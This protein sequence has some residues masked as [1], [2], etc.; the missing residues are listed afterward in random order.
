MSQQSDQDSIAFVVD[1]DLAE[2]QDTQQQTTADTTEVKSDKQTAMPDDAE[3]NSSFVSSNSDSQQTSVHAD[4]DAELAMQ[5]AVQ[6]LGTDTPDYSK[7]LDQCQRWC[8]ADKHQL[9][10]DTL[11]AIPENLRTPEIYSE[12]GRAYNNVAKPDEE[13]CFKKALK[14]LLPYEEYFKQDHRW[15]FRVAY[16][17]YYLDQEW[18]A[19]YY[20]AQALEARPGDQDSQNFIEDCR[21]GLARPTFRHNF[22]DRVRTMWQKFNEHEQEWLEKINNAGLDTPVFN[23]IG[24]VLQTA[25]NPLS[26]SI[27][28]NMLKGQNKVDPDDPKPYLI[29]DLKQNSA[30]TMILALNYLVRQAPDNIKQNWN[31]RVGQGA[32]EVESYISKHFTLEQKDL[33]FKLF[34]VEETAKLD[35]ESAENINSLQPSELDVYD[36][37]V[38]TGELDEF[39][40]DET[41]HDAKSNDAVPNHPMQ[42]DE[43]A[44]TTAL[45]DET[46][47]TSEVNDESVLTSE[48]NDET[49]I[50]AEQNTKIACSQETQA[51]SKSST[52]KSRPVAA[53][54]STDDSGIISDPSVKYTLFIYNDTIAKQ[55]EQYY[56]QKTD[57]N[58]L[59]LQEL[60]E[61]VIAMTNQIAGE[62]T[63]LAA[64]NSFRITG[65]KQFFDRL[66]GQAQPLEKLP[67]ALLKRGYPTILTG[68]EFERDF[69]LTK[70]TLTPELDYDAF[71]RFDIFKGES[72]V[73]RICNAFYHQDDDI[74]NL[75][76]SNGI[77]VG[78]IHY[79]IASAEHPQTT[80]TSERKELQDK[81]I[82]AINR[83]PDFKVF[84]KAF[85]AYNDYIDVLCFGDIF[86]LFKLVFDCCDEMTLK[87]NVNFGPF[88][89]LPSSNIYN[90]EVAHQQAEKLASLL[91]R[92]HDNAACT[93][94][95]QNDKA[96]AEQVDTN[97]HDEHSL[98]EKV[99][100]SEEEKAH[101]RANVMAALSTSQIAAEDL[102]DGDLTDD[103]LA[104]VEGVTDDVLAVED[105]SA[106]VA[107]AEKDE[108]T[109]KSQQN[110][111]PNAQQKKAQP[112]RRTAKSKKASSK[113]K[114]DAV[115]AGDVT[116]DNVTTADAT[117][118]ERALAEDSVSIVIEDA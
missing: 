43:L 83:H 32:D 44:L 97:A 79:E 40:L 8:E 93:N 19:I 11:E 100:L 117:T 99:Q 61:S 31:L 28:Q 66:Q 106:K 102:A 18:L 74:I 108:K 56:N 73:P 23:E 55:F 38:A 15:N 82:A 72:R 62:C 88:R 104:V 17:Y 6:T 27:K 20:F 68:E 105:E 77:A 34:T 24:D 60:S 103:A 95:N 81:L 36:D 71:W 63:V 47:L 16:S 118:N 84:G 75:M 90:Q 9:I 80:E 101:L 110:V 30:F 107:L 92:N 70:Y 98:A 112:K 3:Q 50:A 86:M 42:S 91:N 64:I 1:D 48:V 5:V 111:A 113:Q 89:N 37:R 54:I 76:H 14:C 33:F 4:N 29:F 21:M 114:S 109:A 78:F 41:T 35:Q 12:L 96:D 51:Q 57:E 49:V 26:I 85:G 45:N 25:I 87:I 39:V 13:E 22:A 10:I 58:T 69:A 59:L 46:V 115:T 2:V 94:A 7:L 65:D 67:A 53:V 116:A 52:G